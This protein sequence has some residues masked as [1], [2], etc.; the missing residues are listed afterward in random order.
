MKS[1]ANVIMTKDRTHILV[2]KGMSKRMASASNS[3]TEPNTVLYSSKAKAAS[4]L[5]NFS[6][7]WMKGFECCG[8]PARELEAVHVIVTIEEVQ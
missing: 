3:G 6:S 2:G 8:N 1:H 7:R 5:Q 4:M